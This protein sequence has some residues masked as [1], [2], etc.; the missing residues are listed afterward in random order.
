MVW[1][2]TVSDLILIVSQCDLYLIVQWFSNTILWICFKSGL[3]HWDD[4]MRDLIQIV[5]Q[6]DLYFMVQ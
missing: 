5:G 1:A 6:C 4:T 3:M 2:D